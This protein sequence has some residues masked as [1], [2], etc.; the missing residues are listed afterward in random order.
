MTR[1]TRATRPTRPTCP[2]Q[3]QPQINRST[4]YRAKVDNGAGERSS[5]E[6]IPGGELGCPQGDQR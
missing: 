3:Q 1:L 6:K 5:I 4:S 2:E